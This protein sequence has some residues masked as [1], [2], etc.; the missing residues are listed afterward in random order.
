MPNVEGSNPFARFSL[1]NGRLCLPSLTRSGLSA[2]AARSQRRGSANR[3]GDPDFEEL[4][5]NPFARFVCNAREFSEEPRT[6]APNPRVLRGAAPNE[7][8]YF[9]THFERFAC[10][11]CPN[12]AFT[13]PR[14]SHLFASAGSSF[15]SGALIRPSRA[16]DQAIIR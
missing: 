12:I 3:N 10:A 2:F 5:S 14:I 13:S 16:L 4:S 9:G 6:Y 1:G 11:N 7:S 15:I 8:L